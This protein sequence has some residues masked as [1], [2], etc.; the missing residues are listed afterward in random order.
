MLPTSDSEGH[1]PLRIEGELCNVVIH[2]CDCTSNADGFLGCPLTGAC[3]SAGTVGS[4]K[5]AGSTNS[6]DEVLTGGG[7]PNSSGTRM[8]LFAPMVNKARNTLACVDWSPQILQA[9]GRVGFK[10]LLMSRFQ[11]L[12]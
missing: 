8:M 4:G 9:A 12:Q 11:H 6:T 3:R 7:S 1:P 2:V 10:Q 5:Q